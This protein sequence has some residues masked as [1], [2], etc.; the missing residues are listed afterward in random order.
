M[1]SPK[2]TIMT[3][4]SGKGGAISRIGSSMFITSFGILF[5]T[6]FSNYP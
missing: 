4:P 3:S 5:D 1:L 2:P 6:H